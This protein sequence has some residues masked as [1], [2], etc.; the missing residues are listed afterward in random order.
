[1]ASIHHLGLREAPPRQNGL[2]EIAGTRR[3]RW[4]YAAILQ[5]SGDLGNEG[6]GP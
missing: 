5:G 1:L 2:V 4:S 3:N 6:T